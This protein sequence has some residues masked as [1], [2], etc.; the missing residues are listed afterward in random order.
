VLISNMYHAKPFTPPKNSGKTEVAKTVRR[1]IRDG[2]ENWQVNLKINKKGVY[3][4]DYFK[5]NLDI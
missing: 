4:I 5:L 3:F 1:A 2:V